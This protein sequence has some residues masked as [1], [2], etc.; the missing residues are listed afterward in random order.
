MELCDVPILEI[1][2]KHLLSHQLYECWRSGSI[3]GKSSSFTFSG[4]DTRC[5][6][7]EGEEL[8]FLK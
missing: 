8:N 7:R 2:R 3:Q 5:V 4:D 1:V 6:I